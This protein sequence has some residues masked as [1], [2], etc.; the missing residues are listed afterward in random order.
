M[1][2]SRWNHSKWYTYWSASSGETKE[3]QVFE[4]CGECSFTYSDLAEDLGVLKARIPGTDDELIGYAKE[5]LSDVESEAATPG[6]FVEIQTHNG[7]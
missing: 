7:D 3:N 6:G 1:S 4:V 5:F 2:Y